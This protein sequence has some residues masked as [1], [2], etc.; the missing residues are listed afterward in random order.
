ML[1]ACLVFLLTCGCIYRSKKTIDYLRLLFH[2]LVRMIGGT[3][4][5]DL[6][7]D[8]DLDQFDTFA[9]L[10]RV[11]WLLNISPELF[12]VHICGLLHS[13]IYFFSDK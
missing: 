2:R 3:T 7:A 8:L 11:S 12:G 9:T 6:L 5:L 13:F 1:S 10:V 4:L